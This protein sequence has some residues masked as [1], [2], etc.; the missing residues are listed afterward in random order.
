MLRFKNLQMP[1]K[2][3]SFYNCTLK[4]DWILKTQE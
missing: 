3:V 4:V 1:E 2:G